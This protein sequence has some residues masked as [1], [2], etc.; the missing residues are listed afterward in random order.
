MAKTNASTK[1]TR[2]QIAEVHPAICQSLTILAEG[3]IFDKQLVRKAAPQLLS[4]PKLSTAV[5]NYEAAEKAL[6]TSKE[7]VCARIL[8]LLKR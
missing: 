3:G 6:R 5:R 1:T 7:A 2:T 4:D 8:S